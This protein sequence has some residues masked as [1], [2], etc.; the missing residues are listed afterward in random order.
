MERASR[1]SGFIAGSN[2]NDEARPLS[3]VVVDVEPGNYTTTSTDGYYQLWV[4]SG[5]YGI[6]FSLAGYSTYTMTIEVPAGSDLRADVWLPDY[7][8]VPEFVAA[9]SILVITVLLGAQVA[10]KTKAR[11]RDR[12]LGIPL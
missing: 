4:P 7:Q 8:E 5:S 11:H 2:Y 9:F 10:S 3:W 1:V 12:F 6:G